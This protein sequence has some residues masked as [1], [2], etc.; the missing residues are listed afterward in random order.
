MRGSTDVSIRSPL[1][2]INPN[3]LLSSSIC[4]YTPDSFLLLKSIDLTLL[5]ARLRS[6]KIHAL[7]YV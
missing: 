7:R 4:F 1:S 2:A 6:H 3:Q 5:R